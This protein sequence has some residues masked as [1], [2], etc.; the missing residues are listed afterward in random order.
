[1]IRSVEEEGTRLLVTPPPAPV[2]HKANVVALSADGHSSLLAQ[3]NNTQTYTYESTDLTALSPASVMTVTPSS[4]P[5]GSEAVIEISG[6]GLGFV[7][8]LTQAGFGSSD[9]VIRRIWVVSPG[10][11]LMNVGILPQAALGPVN[12]TVTNGLSMLTQPGAL[13]VQ[14]ANPRALM[15]LPVAINPLTGQTNLT[16]GGPASVFAN[17]LSTGT[18]VTVTL[19]DQPVTVTG[20]SNGQ[21]SFVIPAGTSPGPAI[22][23]VRTG[24]EAAPALAITIDPPPPTVV[25]IANTTAGRGDA[26][27]LTISGL[28]T[29][30]FT[31][32][33]HP[34]QISVGDVDQPVQTVVAAAVRGNWEVTFVLGNV[35]VPGTLPLVV[36]QDGRVS[37]PGQLQVR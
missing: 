21:V 6:A 31:G 2:G 27:T 29:D 13:T 12:L 35:Q 9:F 16:P 15:L 10:R 34:F 28:T 4:L 36:T 7:D 24:N 5:A 19:N 18:P 8:G 23:R 1:V 14:A 25:S 22:V 30:G 32:A 33:P 11:M 20:N 37:A 17:N 26:V 3:G